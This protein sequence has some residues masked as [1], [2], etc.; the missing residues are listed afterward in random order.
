[1]MTITK[2]IVIIL[3]IFFLQLPD[4]RSSIVYSRR[5]SRLRRLEARSS[6]E[7]K[8]PPGPP[9]GPPLVLVVSYWV[10]H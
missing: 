8:L 10:V 1:M 4:L 6:L 2:G 7:H 3:E 5:I 9:V